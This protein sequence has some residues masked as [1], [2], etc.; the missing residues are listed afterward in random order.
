MTDQEVDYEKM[1]SLALEKL[2]NDNNPVYSTA[3]ND[4]CVICHNIPSLPVTWNVLKD[5][6]TINDD[7]HLQVTKINSGVYS[8]KCAS[9]VKNM[10]CLTCARDYIYS[11]NNKS[12]KIKCP[13]RCCT[14]K[15][16]GEDYYIYMYGDSKRNSD[17]GAE[18]TIWSLLFQYGVLNMKCYKCSHISKDLDELIMHPRIGCIKRKAPCLKCNQLVQFDE[19]NAHRAK[20]GKYCVISFMH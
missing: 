5:Y 14:G 8:I 16:F 20:C 15:N 10:I 7:K 2:N 9:S 11:L 17:S 1:S 19:I 6:T 3:M 12:N 18:E 13:F 4:V